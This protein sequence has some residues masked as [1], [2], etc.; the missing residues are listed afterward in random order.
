MQKNLNLTL[1]LFFSVNFKF[2]SKISR[3]EFTLDPIKSGRLKRELILRTTNSQLFKINQI[4]IVFVEIKSIKPEALFLFRSIQY[5]KF[6][7]GS[8]S[9]E[10]IAQYIKIFEEIQLNPSK[11]NVS[12]LPVIL[13]NLQEPAFD[14]GEA[15]QP[16]THLSLLNL[17]VYFEEPEEG[18]ETK[19][20]NSNTFKKLTNWHKSLR[21]LS[22]NGPT[23]NVLDSCAFGQFKQIHLLQL[24]Y[25][26]LS[27]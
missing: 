3:I 17:E 22:F 15:L 12:S 20:L 18:F 4:E 11:L 13:V 2:D 8:K 27:E 25:L 6:S 14:I 26:E 24:N 5:I 9:P 21:S 23:I 7:A 10:Y 19:H 16:L 1:F